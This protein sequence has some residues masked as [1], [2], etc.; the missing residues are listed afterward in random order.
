MVLGKAER[1]REM[2]RKKIANKELVVAPGASGPDYARIVE[3]AGFDCVYMTG[4]GTVGKVLG[5]PDVGLI[6]ITEMAMNVRHI[7]NVTNIPL[8]ADMDTGFGN[9]INVIRSVMEYETAGASGFHMEDQISPKKCG[10]MTGKALISK[11]EMVGKIKAAV[12]ARDD[13][14]L[15]IIAR[16]DARGGAKGSPEEERKELYDRCN[17]Y[18]KAGADV[19][20]PER[21]D[22]PED[23]RMDNKMI[24]APLLLNGINPARYGTKGIEDVRKL[25]YAIVILPGATFSPAAEAAWKYVS[26][27][28]KTGLVPT[29]LTIDMAK[30]ELDYAGVVGLYQTKEWEEK[31]LPTEEVLAR[32]GTKEVPRKF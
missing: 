15:L 31:F 11:E 12:E 26:E 25:G 18:A 32:Y 29:R 23:L 13:P 4:F 14:N 2:L 24:K 21:P 16:C 10:F 19:V 30:P 20:F 9:A 1:K 8:I 5:M 22:S 17:A 7:A 3:K 6:S 27:L 28:K